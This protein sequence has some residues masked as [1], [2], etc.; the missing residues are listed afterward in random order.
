MDKQ[1]WVIIFGKVLETRVTRIIPPDDYSAGTV[2]TEAGNFL[3][4]QVFDHEPVQVTCRDEMGEYTKW[5]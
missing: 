1:V 2:F 4:Q 3:P 5:E